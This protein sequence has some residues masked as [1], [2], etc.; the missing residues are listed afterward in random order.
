[1][2]IPMKHLF[3]DT[4]RERFTTL[5]KTLRQRVDLV[6]NPYQKTVDGISYAYFMVRHQCNSQLLISTPLESSKGTVDRPLNV[7]C[8]GVTEDDLKTIARRTLHIAK[9]PTKIHKDQVIGALSVF[10]EVE[11]ITDNVDQ[12]GKSRYFIVT[13]LHENSVAML[14]D[15]ND[16]MVL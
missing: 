12:R 14:K 1:M 3:G 13:F 6:Q 16:T 9:L 4:D 11:N 7:F 5:V 15:Y 8:E 10:G 2:R